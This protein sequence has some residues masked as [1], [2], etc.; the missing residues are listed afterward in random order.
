MFNG[1]VLSIPP[2][3]SITLH[4]R[5]EGKKKQERKKRNSNSHIHHLHL[6]RV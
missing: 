5:E 1:M 2:T 6:F 3:D 4:S